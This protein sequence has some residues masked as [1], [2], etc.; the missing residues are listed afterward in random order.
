MANVTER[1]NHSVVV[2]N[3]NGSGG[4]TPVESFDNYD[5]AKAFVER[6]NFEL[7]ADE[8]VEILSYDDD[9]SDWES[10]AGPLKQGA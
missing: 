5:A 3:E 4:H 1:K 6:H 8:V 7:E 2:I 10:F 9:S